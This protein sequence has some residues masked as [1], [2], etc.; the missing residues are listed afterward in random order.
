MTAPWYCS[1]QLSSCQEV[2]NLLTSKFGARISDRAH[3]ALSDI[4]IPLWRVMPSGELLRPRSYS[5][6]S[7]PLRLLRFLIIAAALEAG[8]SR[9]LSEDL[10]AGQRI[11]GLTI[12]DPFTT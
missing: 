7:I 3:N 2:L 8:C 11:E 6:I 5:A 12:V 10:H 1:Y 9:L 4:L